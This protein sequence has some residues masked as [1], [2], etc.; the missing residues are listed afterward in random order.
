MS[1]HYYK[2]VAQSEAT[3]QLFILMALFGII[4]M[5]GY[6][7]IDH[8]ELNK[9]LTKKIK[10]VYM[11]IVLSTIGLTMAGPWMIDKGILQ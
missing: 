6:F 8:L 7:G 11:V 2:W 5:L 1:E 3:D 4:L 9:S 10:A